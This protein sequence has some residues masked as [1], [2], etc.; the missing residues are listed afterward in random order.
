MSEEKLMIFIDGSNLFHSGER[1]GEVHL[2]R[3]GFRVDVIKL[4]EKLKGNSNLIRAYYF[5]STGESQDQSDFHAKL[6]YEGI[7]TT[8]KPLRRRREKGVDVALATELLRLGFKK[9]FTRA[10]IVSGDQDY[11]PA[12][13]Y[14]QDEG[15]TVEV[16][17][18]RHSLAKE[19]Q[20]TADK[21]IIVDDFIENM[22]LKKEQAG[23]E[24]QS[25]PA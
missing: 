11:V 2:G 21:I 16:A 15:L 6:R 22:E 7:R 17:S 10:I 19:M 24:N 8:I 18:F 3:E 25:S 13:R 12:I 20:Q 1:Y 23:E 4:I 5:G 9:A 14:V